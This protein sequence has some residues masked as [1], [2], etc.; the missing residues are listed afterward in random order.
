M[1]YCIQ[2]A[3]G[4]MTKYAMV[5]IYEWLINDNQFRD[6]IKTVLTVHDEIILEAKEGYQEIAQEKLSFYMEEAGKLWCK[7]IP[8]KAD[9][10]ISRIW[11]H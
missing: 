9:A 5:L 2:G 6:S 10:V 4:S 1:N 3:A 11:E 8:I 7:R